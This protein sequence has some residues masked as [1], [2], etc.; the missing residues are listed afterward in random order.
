MVVPIRM[1]DSDHT[2]TAPKTPLAIADAIETM[3][4]SIKT[5]LEED[6]VVWG[7]TDTVFDDAYPFIYGAAETAVNRVLHEWNHQMD[8]QKQL[9]Q[10]RGE[11]A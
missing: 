7:R 2:V 8:L 5:A 11:N 9:R 1:K 3:L 6:G 4:A 10:I